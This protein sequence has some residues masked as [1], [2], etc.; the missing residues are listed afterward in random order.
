V[1]PKL[2][3]EEVKNT[4]DFKE[5]ISRYKALPG[6]II[7]AYHAIQKE[8]SYLPEE[9]IGDAA[10][11]FGI[12]LAKAYGVATFYSM[13][14]VKPR[15]KNIIRVCESAPCKVAD[16]DKLV[17]ILENELGIKVGETTPDGNFTLESTQ[18]VGQCQDTPIITIN[19]MPYK[20]ITPE[21]LKNILAEMA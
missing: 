19:S 18:C 10:E 17:K 2:L 11:I 20:D 9:A 3:Y 14:T 12:S 21:K 6:G 16:S 13:F 1:V 8:C 4:A 15:G 5:I 7:E